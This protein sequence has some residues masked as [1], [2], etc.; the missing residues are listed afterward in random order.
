MNLGHVAALAAAASA[1]ALPATEPLP[2]S[3]V[4]PPQEDIL[5]LPADAAIELM[6]LRE[7]DSDRAMPGDPVRLRVNRPVMVGDI[8]VIPVGAA[9]QG[10]V[11]AS[12]KSGAALHRGHLSVSITSITLG[13]TTIELSTTLEQHGRG[14]ANDDALKALL[15]PMWVLF[16]RGNAARLKAGELL[17][18]R[19]EREICFA[20]RPSG[21]APVAC[22][23]A[24]S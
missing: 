8:E 10:V 17:T 16:A 11:T 21:L 20:R 24:A 2:L 6:V 14:G 4:S 1:Q 18:A 12:R 3:A 15:A 9:A 13:E 22:P 5:H 19:A 7:V 23:A